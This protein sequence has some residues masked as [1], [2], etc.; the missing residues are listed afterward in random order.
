MHKEIFWSALAQ[1]ISGTRVDSPG[2][3]LA[4]RGVN[5]PGVLWVVVV[6]PLCCMWERR[7]K[8]ESATTF[9]QGAEGGHPLTSCC[10]CLYLYDCF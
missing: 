5:P 1:C 3:V 2:G 6:I 9:E 8:W 10:V 4:S 7:K